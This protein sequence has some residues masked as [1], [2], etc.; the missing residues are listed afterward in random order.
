MTLFIE[1][2][3]QKICHSNIVEGKENTV[4]NWHKKLT[5][6]PKHLAKQDLARTLTLKKQ[7]N[8]TPDQAPSLDLLQQVLSPPP[9][10]ALSFS[11]DP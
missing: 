1:R 9:P 10:L 8:P 7:K 6:K 2:E 11:V 5:Q 4:K 3:R